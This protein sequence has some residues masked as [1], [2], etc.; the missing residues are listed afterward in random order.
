MQIEI[1]THLFTLLLGSFLVTHI[2]LPKI[3]AVVTYKSLMDDPNQRS[4]HLERTPSL[5]GIAFFIVLILG[6]YFIRT[7]DQEDKIF[8]I[9]PGLL[10]LFIIGLK[11]DLV[12]LSPLTKLG[13]QL[14][15]VSFVLAN[16]AY[17]ITDL[18][19]FLGIQE[20]SLFVTL[21]ASVFIMVAII[22]AYNLID[23]IDGLAAIVG[24]VIFSSLAVLFFFLGLYFYL[25]ISVLLIGTLLAFLRFNLSS[26]K[27]IFMGDTGSL[28]I[29]F[30]IATAVVRISSLSA[31]QLKSLPFYLDNLP[32]VVMAIL[33]IP[34]F[35]T[36]RVFAIRLLNKRSPFSPDRN[37]IHHVLIDYFN[38][39]H[40]K[41]SFFIGL[42]NLVFILTFIAIST[43]VN[44]YF[45]LFITIIALFSLVYFFYRINFSYAHLRRRLRLKKRFK[46]ALYF[47]KLL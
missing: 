22:N 9:L 31:V 38:L 13:A 15:A 30:M 17:Q 27:K 32:L 47:S 16:P 25:S 40:K 6:F 7:F 24:I 5:G 44:N 18:H 10:I 14:L 42:F 1:Y 20:V 3:I 4:S 11:D 33:I 8:A 46:H 26:T 36:G 19:G 12:V 37:H 23:G 28:I 21:P 41:A 29:G 35:D 39:S 45:L 2:V 34:F 43:S